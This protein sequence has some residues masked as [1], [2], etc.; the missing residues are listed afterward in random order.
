MN[1]LRPLGAAWRPLV[2][3]ALDAL[4]VQGFA[5]ERVFAD[6][7]RRAIGVAA[8]ARLL[9]LVATWNARVDL[10][11]ARDERE[12]VDLFLADALVLAAH[13]LPGVSDAGATWIDVGSGAGAPGLVLQLL[14][15]DLQL[16]LVEPLTK[17]VAFLRTVVGSLG[18][19]A[20]RI[21]HVRSDALPAAACDVAVSRATFSPDEWL[22]EGGRLA[23]RVVWVLLARGD[24]PVH[25]GWRLAHQV[26]YIWP[27]TGVSRRA[28]AFEREP[29]PCGE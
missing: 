13:T 18:L 28:L 3:A 23:R 24:A 17:R 22:V 6:A 5:V 27:L 11:A 29:L 21:E 10:T 7:E 1:K 2:A 20:M 12:L 15:R 9:D 14:R 4:A 26:E 16:T 19:A 8:L 25:S